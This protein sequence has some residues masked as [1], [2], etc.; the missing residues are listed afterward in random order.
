MTATADPPGPTRLAHPGQRDT[1]LAVL[2]EAF[3]ADPVWSHHLPDPDRPGFSRRDDLTACLAADIDGYLDQGHCYL[4]DERAA[5]VWSPPGVRADE[6]ALGE[7]FGRLVDPALMESSLPGFLELAGFRPDDPHFYLH[8]VGAT[9]A[10][11][12]RGLGSLLLRRVLDVCDREGWPAYLEASSLRSAALYERHGFERLTTIQL[13]PGVALH[14][15]V[16][17][18]A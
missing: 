5:A 4:I 3:L 8:L 10:A 1:L 18:P 9:D 15:M 14:P 11:R 2:V 16:R 17:T 7:V 12:G 13:A 6:S